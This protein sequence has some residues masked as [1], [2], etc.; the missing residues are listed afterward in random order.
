ME[1][2]SAISTAAQVSPQAQ[3]LSEAAQQ[4]IAFFV[5]AV[6][7][8]G[9]V[10]YI[11]L[12]DNRADERAKADMAS[13]EAAQAAAEARQREQNE[14]EDKRLERQDEQFKAIFNQVMEQ[15]KTMMGYLFNVV[16]R[17]TSVQS[18]IVEKLDNGTTGQTNGQN[19][20]GV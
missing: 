3:F 9:L 6:V 13:R 11:K 4:G 10:A 12:L 8:I 20:G 16:D 1:P 15:Q 5:L 7:V 14:R 17:N 19:G 2:E 18:K